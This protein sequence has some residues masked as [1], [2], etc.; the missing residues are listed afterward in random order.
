MPR[1]HTWILTDVLHDV[2]LD[3][4]A[5]SHSSLDLQ[6]PHPWAIRKRTLR[7]GLRDGVDAIEV[8]NGALSITLLPTRGMGLWRGDYHGLA[9]GW[10]A[11]VIGPVH[12]R[13][14][15]FAERGGLGWL[16]GFDELLCRCGLASSGPPGED[17]YTDQAG[18]P[19]RET[20]TLHGRIANQ[21]AHYVE[22]RVNLDPP[23]D[24]SILGIVD[25]GGLF[26]P[27]L[28]LT[29]TLTTVPGSNK[30]V[31]HDVVENRGGTPTQMQL[32]Y[33][34]NIGQPFLEAGSRVLLPIRSLAPRDERSAEGIATWDTYA[35]PSPGFVEQCYYCDPASDA[36][37]RTLAMLYNRAADKALVTRWNQREMP[38]FTIWR[39]TAAVADGYVTGFEPGTNY[40]NFRTFER[41]HGRVC[42]LP[43]GGHWECKWSMEVHDTPAAV[44]AV[45]TEIATLQAH[46]PAVVH[47]QPQE[48]FSLA[49]KRAN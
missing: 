30:V 23:H 46:A 35:G 4:F 37:G 39:N 25:E 20:L 28:R 43:P 34:L 40:P 26:S 42:V 17:A 21:P 48:Q 11:P 47:Q 19:R 38:C 18:R 29:A 5:V 24:L 36:S 27:H 1:Y 2:W 8:H 33:H 32:L 14:V 13:H 10:A 3:T 49:G 31:I 45:Q 44:T 12:P 9:L 41:Q 22:V 7:G 16:A 6:T 15:T